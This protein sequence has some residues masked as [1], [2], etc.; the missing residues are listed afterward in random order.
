MFGYQPKPKPLKPIPVAK[1]DPDDDDNFSF[2]LAVGASVLLGVAIGMPQLG[3]SPV[4]YAVSAF[5]FTAVLKS[6]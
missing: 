3:W 2:C 6:R 1:P 4:L 5:L